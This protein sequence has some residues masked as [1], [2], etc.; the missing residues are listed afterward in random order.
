MNYQFDFIRIY[1]PISELELKSGSE[2]MEK[3]KNHPEA[4]ADVPE[5]GNIS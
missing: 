2:K 1:L 5:Y 4:S 3:L